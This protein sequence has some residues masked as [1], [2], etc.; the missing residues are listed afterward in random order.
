V[1]ELIRGAGAKGIRLNELT[2]RTQFIEPKLRREILNSLEESEQIVA[3]RMQQR[4]RPCV[5]Y[6][7]IK[8]A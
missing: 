1:I 6:R 4:G 8:G 5:V 2:R 7:M 3:T